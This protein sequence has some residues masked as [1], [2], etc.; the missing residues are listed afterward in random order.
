MQLLPTLLFFSQ[1]DSIAPSVPRLRSVRLPPSPTD[2]RCQR[3]RVRQ[4]EGERESKRKEQRDVDRQAKRVDF[5]I[6]YG[7]FKAN[8]NGMCMCT[9]LIICP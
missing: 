6:Y 3:Q 4:R 5:Y 7:S 9:N 2:G 1:V 8:I